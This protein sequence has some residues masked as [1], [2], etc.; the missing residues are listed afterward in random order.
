MTG[1]GGDD[2]DVVDNAGDVVIAREGADAPL[3]SRCLGEARSEWR[4]EPSGA[5][6]PLARRS[7]QPGGPM[8]RLVRVTGRERRRLLALRP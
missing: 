6:A 7:I 2:T 3:L 8:G 5:T 1:P 4:F